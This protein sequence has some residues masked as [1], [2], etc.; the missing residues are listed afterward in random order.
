MADAT[1]SSLMPRL[2]VTAKS[3]SSS[4]LAASDRMQMS[5]FFLSDSI[6]RRSMGSLLRS[7]GN[8]IYNKVTFS[9]I[10]DQVV[11]TGFDASQMK[12]SS[13]VCYRRGVACPARQPDGQTF[14]RQAGV[15]SSDDLSYQMK[16]VHIR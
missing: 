1:G 6:S 15:S 8:C 4:A 11:V 5:T 10:D 7:A 16:A 14:E 12:H 13:G 3:A 2:R 9:H